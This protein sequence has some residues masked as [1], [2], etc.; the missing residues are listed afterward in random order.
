MLIVF[1][2][3]GN[4]K[5]EH[6]I[7]PITSNNIIDIITRYMTQIN[8]IFINIMFAGK[9]FTKENMN[10][11]L[12]YLSDSITL[13]VLSIERKTVDELVS[14]IYN[15]D[16]PLISKLKPVAS[17]Q[18]YI[19]VP[20][21][22]S[23]YSDEQRNELLK[24]ISDKLTEK[25]GYEIKL[26]IATNNYIFYDIKYFTHLCRSFGYTLEKGL[27]VLMNTSQTKDNPHKEYAFIYMAYDLLSK[28]PQYA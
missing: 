13:T 8:H 3:N 23:L 14:L 6:I 24:K 18:N 9:K 19:N 10:E 22:I 17:D 12:K 25:N 26:N 15:N 20:T 28:I 5:Y 1:N 7:S 27:E 11:I 2:I 21:I 4:L 16:I